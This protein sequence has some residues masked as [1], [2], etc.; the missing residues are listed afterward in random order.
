MTIGMA[1][2]QNIPFV[3]N[4]IG[5]PYFPWAFFAWRST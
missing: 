5:L 3:S 2:N 1:G 4:G